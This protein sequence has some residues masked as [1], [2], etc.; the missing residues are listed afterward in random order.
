MNTVTRR[1]FLKSAPLA[2]FA[3]GHALRSLAADSPSGAPS[4]I[5]TFDYR[6]VRLAP[7]RWQK[8][9]QAAR[10]FWL[11]LPDD[12]ILHGYRAAAGLPAPGK[13]LGGWCGNNS[14]TVF[15]QWLSGMSRM[16][17]ATDDIAIRDKAVRLFTEWA[18]TVKP[19]GDCGMRHYPFEKLVCGLVD[20][21]A[22]ADF[23]EA[24]PMLEKVTD[25]AS[26][27]FNH[28]NVPSAPQRGLYSGRPSE[29]YTLA[30]N[31]YRAF[32][33]TGNPKFKEFAAVWLYHPYWN[34]FAATNSPPDAQGVHA[35]SHVNT[36]SSAA[37]AYA[38]TGEPR[39]LQIVKNAYEYLQNCQCYVTGGY[40]PSEFIVDPKGGLGRALDTRQDTF[41]TACGSWAV[42]KMGR[43]LMQFTGESRYGDWIERILYNG[44]GAA[45]PV[46]AEGKNFYYSDYRVDGGMKVYNWEAW[47]CCSGSYIQAVADYHN[48][49][50]FKDAASL[51]VNLYLPSDVTWS[52]AGGDVKLVQSTSYPE[53]DT[54]T[55]K[56][57]LKQ[58]ATFPLKFRI[59]AWTR[60]AAIKVNGEAATVD[61]KLGTW[62]V[63]ERN[64][65]NGDTV[66]IRIPMTVRT[67]PVDKE[68]PR[69]VAVARGPV[70]MVFEA[71]YH[72]PFFRLPESDE[73]LSKWL[74][75]DTAGT[76]RVQPPDGS[77]IRSK[78]VPFYTVEENY[79]YKMY[80]D[81]DRLP[82]GYW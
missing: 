79:P 67:V 47:T 69:R 21:K 76:F 42:F 48:V 64:W 55:L 46:T 4:V 74:V 6:G 50:Y 41:E 9:F 44:I 75:A 57:E 39:F 2:A 31:L 3:A 29:W 26:K 68:H 58:S 82:I 62:A 73:E 17:R 49:I 78:F 30:E 51:Y 53:A 59:P 52:R 19:D 1:H 35:Y 66:E 45:L 34:K 71:A 56:L 70:A 25:Y 10:D 33:L 36:W 28:E 27:N 38:V 61:C 23:P 72:D 37:M 5:E 60:D 32:Q 16:Y 63:V 18:K 12:D 7:S 43:Y 13:A 20:M 80:F 81:R 54:S 15:G 11:N 40:G 22:Y 24:I 8:Q 65:K 77:R 14:N